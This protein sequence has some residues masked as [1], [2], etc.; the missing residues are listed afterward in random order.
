MSRPVCEW[1]SS[2]WVLHE[3]K[4]ISDAPQLVVRWRL[5]DAD[6]NSCWRK[7]MRCFL[8]ATS[9]PPSYSFYSWPPERPQVGVDS[10]FN[11]WVKSPPGIIPESIAYYILE[12]LQPQKKTKLSSSF[13][14]YLYYG[15]DFTQPLK[16]KCN[17]I[18]LYIIFVLESYALQAWVM[19]SDDIALQ[20]F[21][22]VLFTR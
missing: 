1:S 20:N 10:S 22:I 13:N 18:A 17:K 9:G 4:F 14:M 11:S 15:H 6:L 12:W 19:N 8:K 16:L 7:W 3:W 21:F 5:M 2:H